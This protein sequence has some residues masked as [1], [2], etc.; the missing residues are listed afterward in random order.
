TVKELRCVTC[1]EPL[2]RVRTR[3]LGVPRRREKLRAERP[4]HL[5]RPRIRR[6]LDRDDVPGIDE[7]ARDEIETLL[8]AVH[9]QDLF[10]T[11]LDAEAQQVPREIASERRIASRRVVLE[12]LLALVAHDLVQDAAERLGRK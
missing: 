6:L 8:R 2:E 10:R 5:R 11:R 3:A 12:D 1:D 9:D 4:E 7:R